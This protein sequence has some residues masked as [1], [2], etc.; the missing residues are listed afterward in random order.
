MTIDE[1]LEQIDDMVDKAWSLP[2]SGGKC[3]V[4]AAR[5]RAI[6][7]DGRANLPSELRQAKAIVSDRAEIITNAKR[8]AEDIIR[9]AEERARRMMA[10]EEIYKQAQTAA[11][12]L[13]S[14]SQQKAR[15]MRKGATD[16]AEDVLRRTEEVLA[17][18][19]GDVRQARQLLRNPSRFE[20][21]SAEAEEN[22]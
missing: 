19:I 13:L 6:V 22:A 15:E 14:Q 21:K 8:E 5:L 10:E 11:S 3:L 16:F 17:G 9:K 4:E 12:E 20:E 2:L 18:R 1:L 7:D